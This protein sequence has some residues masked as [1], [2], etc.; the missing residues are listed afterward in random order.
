[1]APDGALVDVCASTGKQRSRRDYL[2]R[3]AIL[4]RDPRGGAM[5]LLF[6]VEMAEWQLERRKR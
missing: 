1:V 5:A 3:P 2:D 4:G 6:A